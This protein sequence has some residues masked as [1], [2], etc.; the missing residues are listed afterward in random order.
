MK[1][2]HKKF[3][4][5]TTKSYKVQYYFLSY[6][7]EFNFTKNKQYKFWM[8]ESA[9]IEITDGPKTY[10][11]IMDPTDFEPT[12]L[13]TPLGQSYHCSSLTIHEKPANSSSDKVVQDYE[14]K[15]RLDMHNFQVCILST[16]RFWYQ[17][18]GKKENLCFS[19]YWRKIFQLQYVLLW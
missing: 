17:K 14:N 4:I 9:E 15:V 19:H 16:I 10:N 7:M 8:S 11:F 12:S 1:N 5:W 2:E 3:Q 18:G 6:S 13:S